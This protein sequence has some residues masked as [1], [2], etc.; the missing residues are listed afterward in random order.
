MLVVG[1][2][3]LRGVVEVRKSVSRTVVRKLAL[4]PLYC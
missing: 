1:K 2:I 4:Y 3:G